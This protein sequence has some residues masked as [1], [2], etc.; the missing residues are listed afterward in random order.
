MKAWWIKLW[1]K[2]AQFLAPRLPHS[3]PY[4]KGACDPETIRSPS[5]TAYS[6]TLC[7]PERIRKKPDTRGPGA[8]GLAECRIKTPHSHVIDFLRRIKEMK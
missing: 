1:A 2:I 5:P 4:S 3:S 6:K 7:K 8:C